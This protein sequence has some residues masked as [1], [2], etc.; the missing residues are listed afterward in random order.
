[1]IFFY[2]EWICLLPEFVQSRLEEF[3]P[4]QP[5]PQQVLLE[6]GADEAGPRQGLLLDAQSFEPE[7]PG[8]PARVVVA[9]VNF[10]FINMAVRW[11]FIKEKKWD[12]K[13]CFLFWSMAWSI[14]LILLFFLKTC[15]FFLAWFL[16]YFFSYVNSHLCFWNHFDYIYFV[17]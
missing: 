13:T 6:V 12:H 3:H 1:M 7:P 17:S 5:L 9:E 10:D 14:A 11:E 15:F 8:A 2:S 16:A 4:A